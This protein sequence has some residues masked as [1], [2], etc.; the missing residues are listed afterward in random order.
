MSVF[1]RDLKDIIR[2]E[3]C[4]QEAGNGVVG[5]GQLRSWDCWEVTVLKWS[6]APGTIFKHRCVLC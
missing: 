2:G 4:Q 1:H 3:T 5:E 6:D